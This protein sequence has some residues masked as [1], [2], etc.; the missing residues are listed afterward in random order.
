M[1]AAVLL[2]RWK[3]FQFFS[4]DRKSDV[5]AILARVSTAKLVAAAREKRAHAVAMRLATAAALTAL[6]PAAASLHR[7]WPGTVPGGW[8]ALQYDERPAYGKEASVPRSM[9]EAVSPSTAVARALTRR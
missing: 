9:T 1:L 5:D 4:I 3:Q 7:C 2:V 6:L 8:H